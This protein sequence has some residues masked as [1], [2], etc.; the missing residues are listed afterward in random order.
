MNPKTAPKIAVMTLAAASLLAL[1]QPALADT[2]RVRA[3]GNFAEGFRWRPSARHIGQG[4]RIRWKNPDSQNVDHI[5]KS[6]GGNWDYR[7]RLDP[8]E[9]VVKRFN[10]LGRFKYRCTLHSDL[11]NGDCSGMCGRVVTHDV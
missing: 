8:G 11:N 3:S 6:Y 10:R 9:S 1:G 7:R 5:V 2:Y 4:E